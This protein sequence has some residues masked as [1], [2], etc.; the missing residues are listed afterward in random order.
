MRVRV[1]KPFTWSHVGGF[2]RGYTRVGAVA[3]VSDADGSEMIRRGFV[4]DADAPVVS[5]VK[6]PAAPVSEPTTA[7]SSQPVEDS[8]LESVPRPRRAAPVDEWRA[9]AES[10]GIDPKGMSKPELIAAVG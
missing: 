7:N 4:V 1:V 2:F 10:Q 9:Y 3:V 5:V 6:E 8:A